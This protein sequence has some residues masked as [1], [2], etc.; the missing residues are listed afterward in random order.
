[1]CHSAVACLR[2]ISLLPRLLHSFGSCAFGDQNRVVCLRDV[3]LLPCLLPGFLKA[4]DFGDQNRVACLPD[5][6]LSPS[7]LYCIPKAQG[8]EDQNRIVCFLLTQCCP[9]QRASAKICIHIVFPNL[10]ARES[11]AV[12]PGPCGHEAHASTSKAQGQGRYGNYRAC[13]R[14][15]P[16]LGALG[17]FCACL[18]KTMFLTIVCAHKRLACALLFLCFI[19]ERSRTLSH[20][21]KSCN[22]AAHFTEQSCKSKHARPPVISGFMRC[23]VHMVCC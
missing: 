10:A 21:H 9:K 13:A 11:S 7:L 22:R 12:F 8:L 18:L 14:Q 23:V 1:M 3:C 20:A 17:T 16:A 4:H 2:D 15:P 6:S 5:V 19:R